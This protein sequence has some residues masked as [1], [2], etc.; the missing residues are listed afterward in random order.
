MTLML[1]VS[2]IDLMLLGGVFVTSRLYIREKK[3]TRFVQGFFGKEF[4]NAL[5]LRDGILF[6]RF[7]SSGDADF[8]FAPWSHKD[9]T[10][11]YIELPKEDGKEKVH[12]KVRKEDLFRLRGRLNLALVVEDSIAA[13]PPKVMQIFS[14]LSPGEK[15]RFLNGYIRYHSNKIRRER[16]LQ[17]LRFPENKEDVEA[18]KEQLAQVDREMEEI[19]EKWGAIIQEADID[20]T[21]VLKDESEKKWIFLRP[22]RIDEISE[23]LE[24]VKP[25]EIT[26]TARKILLDWQQTVLES[27]KKLVLPS[28]NKTSGRSSFMTMILLVGALAF[29]LLMLMGRIW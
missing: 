23:Y 5:K 18:L 1:G 21:I 28:K 8:Y 19:K 16:I 25:D 20:G 9:E 24:A 29:L 22:V 13:V 3:K 2:W 17:E 7:D 14:Q 10:F 4:L 6:L 27:L 12:Y 26:Y 11:F 15:A